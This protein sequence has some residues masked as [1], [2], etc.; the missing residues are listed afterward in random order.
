MPVPQQN[1]LPFTI[2]PVNGSDRIPQFENIPVDPFEE[3]PLVPA[4]AR[5]RTVNGSN[6]SKGSKGSKGN[7]G[8]D[9]NTANT[10]NK[11]KQN[12]QSKQLKRERKLLRQQQ[13]QQLQGQHL[14]WRRY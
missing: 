12:K 10:A 1:G 5:L 11:G 7:K 14:Q 4:N 9:S 6:G 2:V 13:K 8:N 3:D